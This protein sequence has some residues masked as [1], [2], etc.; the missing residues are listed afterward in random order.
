[1]DNEPD[2]YKG[3]RPDGHPPDE[4]VESGQPSVDIVVDF[5]SRL[6]IPDT[7]YQELDACA[8]DQEKYAKY[9]RSVDLII[10]RDIIG[11]SKL[12]SKGEPLTDVNERAF[13]NL[14]KWMMYKIAIDPWWHKALCYYNRV[15]GTNVSAT[16]Y[17]PLLFHPAYIPHSTWNDEMNKS[18]KD[19]NDEQVDRYEIYKWIDNNITEDE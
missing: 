18:P 11:M 16:S 17:W 1:M 6:Q 8:Y 10:L 12:H 9:Y 5:F 2:G 14:L 13:E 19:F 15:M 3:I 4:K 7:I